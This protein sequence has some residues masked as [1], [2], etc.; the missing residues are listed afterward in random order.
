MFFWLDETHVK[1]GD[2]SEKLADMFLFG[3]KNA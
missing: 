2:S 3:N 1:L